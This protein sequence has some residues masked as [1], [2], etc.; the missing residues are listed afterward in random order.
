MSARV[1]KLEE[2]GGWWV[3]N[4][5]PDNFHDF[6]GVLAAFKQMIPIAERG[7]NGETQLWSVLITEANEERLRL[8]FRNFAEELRAMRSQ[9]TLFPLEAHDG[10]ASETPR[11]S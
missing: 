11:M 6:T 9:M 10:E 5:K 7:W 8:L 3:F 1:Q 2:R 4:F